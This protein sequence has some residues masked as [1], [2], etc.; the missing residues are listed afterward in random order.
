MRRRL[1]V[2]SI[3]LQLSLG[4]VTY[5][6]PDGGF[7][8]NVSDDGGQVTIGDANQ[9]VD[10]NNTTADAGLTDQGS[11]LDHNSSIDA[12]VAADHSVVDQGLVDHGA[13]DQ[14]SSV[15]DAAAVDGAVAS[16]DGGVAGEHCEN[17][18]CADG[19]MC[20]GNNTEAYCRL[21]CI[22]DGNDC[23]PHSEYCI[24]IN[25]PDGGIAVNGACVPGVGENASCVD[26]PCAE[27]YICAYMDDPD[28]RSCRVRCDPGVAEGADAGCPS[29][30]TCYGITGTDG[31]ACL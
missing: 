25:L 14:G 27:I 31:G 10:G 26:D 22:L 28:S 19:Y 30:Q 6:D 13:V 4:C 18:A 16:A 5:F 8:A 3:A 11:G 17:S 1:L 2:L 23:D 29:A 7:D 12:T 21:E 9:G 15:V 24:S 20:I